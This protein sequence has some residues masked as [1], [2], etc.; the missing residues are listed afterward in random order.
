MNPAR[1][2]DELHARR[3]IGHGD[4]RNPPGFYFAGNQTPGL[5]AE[6]SNRDHKSKGY[7][8][9]LHG[10]CDSGS[11][12]RGHLIC[13]SPVPNKAEYSRSDFSESAL[14]DES[15][16]RIQWKDYVDVRLDQVVGNV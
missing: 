8:V 11:R 1:R 16:E 5:V 3:K 9:F 15:P 12:L 6:R 4:R 7:S 14:L 2:P 10:R 13:S